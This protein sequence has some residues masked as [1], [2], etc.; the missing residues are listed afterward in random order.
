MQY[1]KS[2]GDQSPINPAHAHHHPEQ[3]SQPD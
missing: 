3:Q 2:I 1:R